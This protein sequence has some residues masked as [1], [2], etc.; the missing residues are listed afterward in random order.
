MAALRIVVWGSGFFGRQW[1]EAVAARADCAVAGIISRT[2]ERLDRL[3]MDLGLAGTP[4]YASLD[5]AVARGRPD[6]VIVAL[7]EMLHRD[8][9]AGA[10]KAGLHVLTEKPLAT[11]L[12]E[13]RAIVEAARARPEPVVMVSQNFRWRPHTRALRRA[14]GDGLVGRPGHLMLVCRQQIRRTTV[15][16]WRER[17]ADPFL[18]DFAIHHLD[19]I[20][21]LTAEEARDV[22]AV[23]FRPA[24]S[25][26]A[27][28][29]AAAAI[30][31]MES[32]LVVDY[33]GT[34]VSQGLET[35]QEG[36]ITVIG[37]TGTLHLDGRSQIQLVQPGGQGE[38]RALAP[39]PVPEGELGHGLAQF[40]DAIRLGRRPETH[41][42]DNVRSFALLVA[43]MEAARAR[44][45]VRP[46][47]LLGFL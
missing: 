15:G 32:G 9:I 3:R 31:T 47:E 14:I 10:L 1:L 40:V 21:Y 24:W 13:A 23:S 39:E 17:M 43:V 11:T 6:A 28:H 41:L 30:L 25:W 29:S 22:V 16:G 44:R 36:L 18:L 4:G 45:A 26:F 20:R 8:A 37:E 38:P 5:E 35:T 33:G 7:P 2:P 34:M 42:E 12:E 19:L 46:A 27:G